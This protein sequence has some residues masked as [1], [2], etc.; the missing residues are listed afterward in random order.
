MTDE[1]TISA[2]T[3]KSKEIMSEVSQAVVGKGNLLHNVMVALLADGHILL[4]DYP[5]LAKTLTAHSFA[6][7]LGLTFKRIQFTPDLLPGDILGGY[8][9]NRN[10]GD[11]E[12][13][14]GPIF[15]QIVLG[16]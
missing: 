8:I 13:H 10:T 16:R 11:F 9:F 15:S 14:K 1:F 3:A 4:E 7:V 2:V 6:Q 5:G 12:L